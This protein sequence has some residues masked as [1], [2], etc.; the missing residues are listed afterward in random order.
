M[1]RGRPT[2]FSSTYYWYSYITGDFKN[3]KNLEEKIIS[4]LKKEIPT[5]IAVIMERSCYFQCRHCLFQKEGSSKEIS[6]KNNLGKI[7]DN[8]LGQLSSKAKDFYPEKPCFVYCGRV[9]KEWH[10]EV[11]KN[12]RKKYPKIE[13]G[14]IDNG[15][16]LK[17]KDIFSRDKIKLDFLDISLDGLKEKHNQ[18]RDP[19]YQKSFDLALEGLKYA[20]QITRGRISV[21]MTITSINYTDIEKVAKL[22][23]TKNLADEFHITTMTPTAKNSDI[24][25]STKKLAKVWQQIKKISKKYNTKN[26]HKIFF[27]LYRYQ[28]LN[29]LK[30]IIGE[31]KIKKILTKNNITFDQG[32]IGF[33]LENI[34]INYFPFSLW[35]Q[36]SILIDA[37]G[38]NRV[39]FSQKFTLKQLCHDKNKKKYTIA[40]L[41]ENENYQQVYLREV[42]WWWKNF[43]K[44]FLGEEKIAFERIGK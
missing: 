20:R 11:I 15:S 30:T 21:L 38:A 14:L 16:Y 7:I 4:S 32:S 24:E 5:T 40:K 22:I 8:F 43:G 31:E 28:D 29:K 44:N 25:I 37:D 13:I 33:N 39:A 18:Q 42:E 35:P 41:R 27:K 3:K 12:I 26:K 2:I 23:F 6:Q 36:E 1:K 34:Q 17:F 9:L 10:F 19:I